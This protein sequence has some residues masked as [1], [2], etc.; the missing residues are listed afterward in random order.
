MAAFPRPFPKLS[1]FTHHQSAFRN[2][3]HCLGVRL[4]LHNIM[5]YF[6]V[7]D[8]LV[9][10]YER[11]S[12]S[13]TS[14]VIVLSFLL[15]HISNSFGFSTGPCPPSGSP[16]SSGSTRDVRVGKVRGR[17]RGVAIWPGMELLFSGP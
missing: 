9:H 10:R 12:S 6:A 7:I 14:S 15:P 2:G 5:L 16:T 11:G 8:T 3:E 4:V 1:Q 13:Q 17:G